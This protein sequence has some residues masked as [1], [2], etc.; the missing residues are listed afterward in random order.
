MRN[1]L[2]ATLRGY[3]RSNSRGQRAKKHSFCS[4]TSYS[5]YAYSGCGWVCCMLLATAY[6]QHDLESRHIRVALEQRRR[7]PMHSA[8]QRDIEPQLSIHAD[9]MLSGR[10][11]RWVRMIAK[12]H[13]G[14][15]RLMLTWSC[16]PHCN[17]VALQLE[18][19]ICMLFY[20]HWRV[21]WFLN[22][23]LQTDE[24]ISTPQSAED[25]CI[26]STLHIQGNSVHKHYNR[27][28]VHND[29]EEHNCTRRNIVIGRGS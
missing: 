18:V 3:V 15:C 17:P 7:S 5:L 22:A 13:P 6:C 27:C 28:P 26:C 11:T 1:F 4:H 9:C 19:T 29:T 16:T 10:P 14:P 25:A 21:V 2:T 8:Q 23:G 12:P 24:T 20:L